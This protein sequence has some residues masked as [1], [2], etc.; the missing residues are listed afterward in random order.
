VVNY[1][2]RIVNKVLGGE[3]A[4]Y[5][6]TLKV[7]GNGMTKAEVQIMIESMLSTNPH[8]LSWERFDFYKRYSQHFP[9]DYDRVEVVEADK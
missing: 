4:K 3:M 9:V 5:L 6:V 1:G 8:A 7:N 2:T